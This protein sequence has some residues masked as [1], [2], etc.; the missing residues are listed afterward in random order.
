[1]LANNGLPIYTKTGT[2]SNRLASFEYGYTGLTTFDIPESKVDEPDRKFLRLN[3][4]LLGEMNDKIS[5]LL[6]D[7][8]PAA[9]DSLVPFQEQAGFQECGHGRRNRTK[10]CLCIPP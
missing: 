2:P 5:N 4:V 6:A 10:E 7:D 1:L 8:D 3:F 9:T